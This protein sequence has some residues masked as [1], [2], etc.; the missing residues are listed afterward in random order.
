MTTLL[1]TCFGTFQ[2][3]RGDGVTQYRG[4]KYASVKD[5]LSAPELVTE[6]GDAVVD[7]TQYG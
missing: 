7:A 5:Q 1:Q 4:V 2:G 3:K 6:Y